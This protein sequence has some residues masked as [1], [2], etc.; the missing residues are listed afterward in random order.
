MEAK[1]ASAN[2][3]VFELVPKPFE[4]WAELYYNIIGQPPVSFS[5]FWDIYQGI[6]AE[7][8]SHDETEVEFSHMLC[9][10]GS[11][12]Q[13]VTLEVLDII[14]GMRQYSFSENREAVD[15]P[16]DADRALMEHLSDDEDIDLDVNDLGQNV[17]NHTLEVE[18]TT[19]IDPDNTVNDERALEFQEQKVASSQ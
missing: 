11:V 16:E 19:T 13:T 9:T 12:E 14:P 15:N 7:F 6:L 2:H 4:D 8:Q 5:N 3:V 18:L 17:G 10:Q 1:Y